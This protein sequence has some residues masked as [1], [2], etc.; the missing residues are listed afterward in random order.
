VHC[1]HLDDRADM[2]GDMSWIIIDQKKKNPVLYRVVRRQSIQKSSDHSHQVID[3]TCSDQGPACMNFQHGPCL[4]SQIH[5]KFHYKKEDFP[6]HQNIGT[7]TE[8]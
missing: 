7:C 2:A 5:P 6:S 1:L 8:Y 4:V 3:Q